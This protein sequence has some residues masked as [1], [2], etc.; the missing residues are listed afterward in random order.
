MKIRTLLLFLVAAALNAHAQ[1]NNFK[2]GYQEFP[3]TT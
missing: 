3:T 1:I 2:I